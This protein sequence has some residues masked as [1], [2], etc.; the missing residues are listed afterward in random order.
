M[1]RN[2]SYNSFNAGLF[3]GAE[4]S[5]MRGF[6]LVIAFPLMSIDVIIIEYFVPD[7]QSFIVC[8]LSSRRSSIC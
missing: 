8:T 6:A 7:A 5:T 3:M 2:R 4:V 1:K